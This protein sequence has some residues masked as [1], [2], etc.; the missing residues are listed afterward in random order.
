[1]LGIV[2]E[3]RTA[4]ATAFF[5]NGVLFGTWVSRIPAVKASV[6]LSEATLGIALLCMGLGTLLAL[7]IT[8]LLFGRFGSRP[9]V[10]A[11]ALSCC[12]VLP[13]AG[14][15]PS[16]RSLAATLVCFGAA[17]GTMDVAMNAQA[18]LLE[19][20]A[21]RSIMASFHGL[22]SLGGLAGAGLGAVFA[23]RGSEPLHHF[24]PVSAALAVVGV[25]STRGLLR[26]RPDARSARP[27]AWPSRRALAVGLLASCGAVIE[28]GIAE[29]SG[30]YLRESLGAPASVAATGFAV[31]SL[32]MMVGRFTGDRLIDRLGRVRLLTGG[33]ALTGAALA[34]ALW[35]GD[36]RAA[37]V[38]FALA[39]LGMSTVFPIAFSVA[40]TLGGTAP[41]HAIAA[42]ATMA[43]G[44][45]L[46]GP[47]LIGFAA[48]LTSLPIALWVLVVAATA[49]TAF[50]GR[51]VRGRPGWLPVDDR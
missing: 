45:G 36:A 21:G 42:V 25:A 38:A 23:A 7:P 19:R 2:Q 48:A 15:A 4:V 3:A 6:S 16:L 47:P 20:T 43:Y 24:V 10:G 35:W 29:W 46:A 22:W 32:T 5:V 31:F 37:L 40:G 18:A 8:T 28:G 49:I 33:S 11:A 9:V 26:D 39:G 1:M 34:G 50:A 51:A 17:M 44:A 30:V 14:G 13:L 41:G 27:R 12:L